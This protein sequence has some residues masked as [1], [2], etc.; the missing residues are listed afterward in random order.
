MIP[1]G[2][3]LVTEGD[4]PRSIGVITSSY[5]SPTLKE[6]IALAL[7][8]NGL[9]R[10]GETVTVWHMGKRRSGIVTDACFFDESGDRLRA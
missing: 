4:T 5:Y 2:A 6:P 8:E 3:H 7:L 10:L 1:T 9:A